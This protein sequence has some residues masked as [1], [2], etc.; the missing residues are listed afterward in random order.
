MKI[1]TS[2]MLQ[3]IKS[4]AIKLQ[5]M[6]AREEEAMRVLKIMLMQENLQKQQI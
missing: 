3:F 2:L 4:D 5:K 6:V 1:E